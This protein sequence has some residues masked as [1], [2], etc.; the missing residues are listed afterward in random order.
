MKKTYIAPASHSMHLEVRQEL[1]GASNITTLDY[2]V[3]DEPADKSTV[4]V[5]DEN[6]KLTFE[7]NV[8]KMMD[9][10]GEEW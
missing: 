10:W 4:L 1:L 8:F 7:E 3:T 5:K 6:G 9:V 2:N